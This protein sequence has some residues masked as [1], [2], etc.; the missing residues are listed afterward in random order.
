MNIQYFISIYHSWGPAFGTSANWLSDRLI[1]Y[2]NYNSPFS[3]SFTRN[4]CVFVFFCSPEKVSFHG[5]L[6]AFFLFGVSIPENIYKLIHHNQ[7]DLDTWNHN[8]SITTS[9]CKDILFVCNHISTSYCTSIQRKLEKLICK[10]IKT[11]K[12]EWNHLDSIEETDIF[13]STNNVER[14][15][16]LCFKLKIDW[17]DQLRW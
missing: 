13:L 7:V 9:I 12:K 8:N 5:D 10:S 1:S 4:V 15:F 6:F 16:F 3:D 14:T 2:G 11:E 17:R